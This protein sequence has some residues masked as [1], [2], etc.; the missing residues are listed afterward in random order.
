MLS[1]INLNIGGN[2]RRNQ[3]EHKYKSALGFNLFS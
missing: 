3:L 1:G 2:E